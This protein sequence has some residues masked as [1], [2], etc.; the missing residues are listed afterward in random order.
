MLATIIVQ[1]VAATH[2][3]QVVARA[4]ADCCRVRIAAQRSRLIDN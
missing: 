2:H 1:D 4:L 3:H